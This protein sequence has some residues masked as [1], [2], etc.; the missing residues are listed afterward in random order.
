MSFA[1]FTINQLRQERDAALARVAALE[2]AN[3]ALRTKEIALTVEN[4]DQRKHR[5]ADAAALSAEVRRPE[6]ANR[7]LAEEIAGLQ[8]AGRSAIEAMAKDRELI[9]EISGKVA[10]ERK[11]VEYWR[12]Q[13]NSQ[14]ARMDA[15]LSAKGPGV[16]S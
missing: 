9:L 5:T 8:A 3:T 2:E 10:E 16:K 14:T 4:D 6:E 12:R 1:S 11:A 13:W 7:G 15:L